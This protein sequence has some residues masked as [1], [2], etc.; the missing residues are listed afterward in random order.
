[1]IGALK[2]PRNPRDYNNLPLAAIPE[3]K[4]SILEENSGWG[5]VNT[6]KL[7]LLMSANSAIT[8]DQCNCCANC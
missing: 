6:N 7:G 2:S 5:T 4:D 1:M 8:K 3:S